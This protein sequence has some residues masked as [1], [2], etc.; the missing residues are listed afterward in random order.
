MDEQRRYYKIHKCQWHCVKNVI[1]LALK[2]TKW[3]PCKNDTVILVHCVYIHSVHDVNK[4]LF[5]QTMNILTVFQRRDIATTLIS[6]MLYS[7][8]SILRNLTAEKCYCK[9]ILLSSVVFFPYRSML[10]TTSDVYIPRTQTIQIQC[11]WARPSE[12]VL[13]Q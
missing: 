11:S 6:C 12:T 9:D 1:G 4:H 7:S 8:R 5:I 10:F 2:L 13:G 3:H